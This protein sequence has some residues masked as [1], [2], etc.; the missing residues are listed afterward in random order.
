MKNIR[1]GCT[2]NISTRSAD[3]FRGRGWRGARASER[4]INRLHARY[5]TKG[6]LRLLS[7]AK[8]RHMLDRMRAERG[9]RR[10][11]CAALS[12][13]APLRDLMDWN[14][15]KVDY[16]IATSTRAQFQGKQREG[17][18]EREREMERLKRYLEVRSRGR[19]AHLSMKNGTPHPE[20]YFANWLA[21]AFTMATSIDPGDNNGR[22]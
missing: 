4:V 5:V 9:R 7:G 14:G 16:V 2:R 20:L 22:A 3:V 18:G 8:S 15:P 21:R 17:G 19:R 1:R 11:R 10:R 12:I 6:P 13:C